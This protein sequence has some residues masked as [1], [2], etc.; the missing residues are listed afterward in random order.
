MTEPSTHTE[1]DLLV[2]DIGE[3]ATP[4]GSEPRGGAALGEIEVLSSAAVAVEGGLIVEVGASD[5]LRRRYRARREL[6]AAGKLAV[7]GFVDSH[8][9]PVFAG[10]RED[11]FEM[12]TA[13]ATYVE[14][15]AAGGGILSSVRGVRESSAE[16]L[17]ARLLSRLDRFL[18]L[19]TT[20][21]EAKTG[22]GL[23]LADE[24]KCLEVIAQADRVHPVELVAT[25]LPAHDYP[26]EY[27]D[28]REDYEA[29]VVQEMLPAAAESGRA[30]YAD[31]F[32]ESCAFDLSSS[33]RI[34]R[35]ALELG[36]GL[37]MHVDQLSPLGGAQLA[38]ELGAASADHLEFVSEE[39]IE[40]M[41]AAGVQPVL[42][43]V[44]PLYLRVEQEAPARRMIEAG[45]APALATDFNPGSCYLQSLPEV[46]SWAA[47]RLRL[48]AA[49]ALAAATLNAACS[50][51]RGASRGSLEAGKR[52]DLC[53]LDLP[54]FRHLTYEMGRNPVTA[55]VAGGAVVL[56]R[57]APSWRDLAP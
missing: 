6:D 16:E 3:L 13:G 12:R 52:A 24:L 4:R 32:T 26:A 47:L 37:R 50:L 48:T 29:L 17:L 10:T 41:G 19:G 21:V 31:V 44:V 39:G 5:E 20:T 56:E 49:E 9:H 18:E 34:M 14:I 51:G 53:L 23:S 1:V 11:E 46:M 33:R 7:P 40:A 22:Y 43:P 2:H 25:F 45:L 27:R 42:C 36:F 30:E 38:A 28:R 55:V 57:E 54:N 15:G 8:T 35:R